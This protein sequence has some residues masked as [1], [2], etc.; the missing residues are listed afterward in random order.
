MK[1][2]VATIFFLVRLLPLFLAGCA[3]QNSFVLD[4]PIGPPSRETRTNA[5]H[6][7]LLVYSAWESDPI[8]GESSGMQYADYTIAAL[9]GTGERPVQNQAAPLGRRSAKDFRGRR[10]VPCPPS[11]R[12][13][14]RV[15]RD[16]L[17]P[18]PLSE[19]IYS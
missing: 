10:G 7:T 6:G 1:L 11:K 4:V 13:D 17:M 19:T 2:H 16:T 5:R 12:T 3:T 15:E 9:D 18:H 14:H 8:R